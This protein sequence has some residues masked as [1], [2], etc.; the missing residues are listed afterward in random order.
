MSIEIVKFIQ[1]MH[2]LAY[3]L[4]EW[5]RFEALLYKIN[6]SWESFVMV[7][8]FI[9]IIRKQQWLLI[10]KKKE[11]ALYKNS[12]EIQTMYINAYFISKRLIV[13]VSGDLYCLI[14]NT[15]KRNATQ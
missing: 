3:S 13:Y 11:K 4:L 12:C 6:T 7:I 14:S 1:I 9:I 15:C 8:F 10:A 2:F 5:I